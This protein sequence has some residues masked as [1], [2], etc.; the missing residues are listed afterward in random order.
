MEQQRIEENMDELEEAIMTPEDTEDELVEI[1]VEELENTPENQL[2]VLEA[3]LF[4]S[5]KPLT[6][7]IMLERL[8]EGADLN[9]LLP[10]LQEQYVGRGVELSEVGGQWAFRTV[11]DVGAS[12]TV[13]KEVSRKMSKAALETMAIVAYHQ[14]ITR[15]EIENIRGVATHKERLIFSWR[16]AGLNQGVGVKRQVGH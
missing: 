14:P 9:I 8:P 11:Q 5:S 15:A 10:Q 12:L 3:M 1:E 7:Q 4:A 2:R 13:E 16:W 6:P